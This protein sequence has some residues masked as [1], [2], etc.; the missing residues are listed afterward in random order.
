MEIHDLKNG[1]PEEQAASG[2]SSLTS[3]LENTLQLGAQLIHC[4]VGVADLAKAELQLAIHSLPRLLMLWLITMPILLITW[5]SF[6]VLIAWCVYELSNIGVL[7]FLV[8]FLM[9]LF[10][11][12]V[13]NSLYRKYRTRMMLPNTS[14]QIRDF[15]KVLNYGSSSKGETKK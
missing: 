12:L 3:E 1:P 13:C 10:L 7:G 2:S 4:A 6:S 9:Q 15:I 14:A 11:L 5:C 8:F